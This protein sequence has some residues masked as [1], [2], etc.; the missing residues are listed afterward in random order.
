MAQFF[1]SI[2]NEK[3]MASSKQAEQSELKKKTYIS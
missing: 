3:W 1:L 2:E